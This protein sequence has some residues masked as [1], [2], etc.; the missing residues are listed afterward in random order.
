MGVSA[1]RPSVSNQADKID[2][3][4]QVRLGY[5]NKASIAERTEHVRSD[6]VRARRRPL[7][8]ARHAS[9]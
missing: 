5:L 6:G 3:E 2:A 1:F 7:L 9:E 4:Q 8:L